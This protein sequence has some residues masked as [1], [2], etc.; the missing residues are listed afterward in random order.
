MNDDDPT[1]LGSTT[2]ELVLSDNI[3][4]KF[5]KLGL[6]AELQVSV[7]A[8]MVKLSGSGKYLNE[9]RKSAKAA[10]MSCIFKVSITLLVLVII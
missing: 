3:E 6:D 7:L 8:G 4:D 5:S 10:R 9:E 1:D 2:V